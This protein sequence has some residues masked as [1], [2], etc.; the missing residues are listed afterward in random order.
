M[1]ERVVEFLSIKHSFFLHTIVIWSSIIYQQS[2]N[3]DN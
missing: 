3:L 2:Q 1:L